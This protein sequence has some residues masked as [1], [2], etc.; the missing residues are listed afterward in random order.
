MLVILLILLR[1]A[2]CVGVLGVAPSESGGG[3][4]LVDT[5]GLF[6]GLTESGI[7]GECL[8]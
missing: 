7:G 3:I 2:T 8:P 4:L 1:R 5:L 6:N